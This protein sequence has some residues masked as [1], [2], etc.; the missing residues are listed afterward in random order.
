MAKNEEYAIKRALRETGGPT[1]SPGR[2]LTCD[3]TRAGRFFDPT[4]GKR[5]PRDSKFARDAIKAEKEWRKWKA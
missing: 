4:S 3:P 1:R 2:T 5:L